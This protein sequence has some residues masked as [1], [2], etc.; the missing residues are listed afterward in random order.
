MLISVA[1]S[2]GES[3]TL[4]VRRGQRPERHNNSQYSTMTGSPP[5]FLI[6]TVFPSSLLLVSMQPT[7]MRKRRVHASR[8]FS[9]PRNVE[10]PAPQ[11]AS[12]SVIRWVSPQCFLVGN[13]ENWRLSHPESLSC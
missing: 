6:V 10:S 3:N 1:S 4:S 13:H 11:T 9:A 5:R 8:A 7:S 12:Q 2:P